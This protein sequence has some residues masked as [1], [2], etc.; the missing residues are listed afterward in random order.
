VVEASSRSEETVCRAVDP[1]ARP[2]DAE[3]DSEEAD[4]LPSGPSSAY[5]TPAPPTRAAP[6]PTVIAP[7]PSQAQG[8][9]RDVRSRGR[10]PVV[11]LLLCRRRARADIEDLFSRGY[12]PA[13]PE[14]AEMRSFFYHTPATVGAPESLPVRCW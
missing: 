9:I 10:V 3:L 4:E 7:A 8:S 11:A 1:L 14:S 12:A 6:M 5:A 13:K 2:S